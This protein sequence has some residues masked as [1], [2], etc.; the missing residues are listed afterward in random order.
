M[1]TVIIITQPLVHVTD[2]IF[3]IFM[4]EFEVKTTIRISAFQVVFGFNG[5]VWKD[6]L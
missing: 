6:E 2:E 5:D 4:L 3:P 1:N